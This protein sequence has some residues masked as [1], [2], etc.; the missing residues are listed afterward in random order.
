MPN[1]PSPKP[2]PGRPR[3]PHGRGSA[4]VQIRL[5]DAEAHALDEWRGRLTRAAYLRLHGMRPP[6]G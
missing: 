2:N 6:G 4:A 1:R 3:G 5:S